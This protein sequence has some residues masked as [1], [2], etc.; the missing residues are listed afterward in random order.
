MDDYVIRDN[1]KKEL[2]SENKAL[3]KEVED[4]KKK[5]NK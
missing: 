1:F 4:L 3:R 5:V 2:I